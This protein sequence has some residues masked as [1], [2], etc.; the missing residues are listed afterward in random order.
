MSFFPFVAF[1]VVE[2]ISPA[3]WGMRKSIGN[4]L[5]SI[6][7]RFSSMHS[8]S[9]AFMYIFLICCCI[10]RSTMTST[11]CIWTKILFFCI[12]FYGSF[13]M[14]KVVRKKYTDEAKQLNT[15]NKDREA[16]SRPPKNTV[17]AKISIL[18]NAFLRFFIANS[19]APNEAW[20]AQHACAHNTR[21]VFSVVPRTAH[22]TSG[23]CRVLPRVISRTAAIAFSVKILARRCKTRRSP[24]IFRAL[25]RWKCRNH[26]LHYPWRS[27]RL[28]A[29][30]TR[31]GKGESLKMPSPARINS[32]GRKSF[33]LQQVDGDGTL[34]KPFPGMCFCALYTLM[35]RLLLL[36]GLFFSSLEWGSAQFEQYHPVNWIL[37]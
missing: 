28:C 34:I 14:P 26:R 13:I 5:N 33:E 2:I 19:F 25:S 32:P 17:P 30:G 3:G 10:I 12:S 18:A 27:R 4:N 9:H 24:S 35:G 15:T 20:R 22:E 11:F 36:F 29:L 21:Y 23:P 37:M 6:S 8:I 16:N 31:G 7:I 1:D